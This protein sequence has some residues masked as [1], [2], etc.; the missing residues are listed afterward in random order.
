MPI[1]NL[2]TEPWIPV[3]D[4]GNLTM[5]SLEQALLEGHR[6]NRLEDPS[7]LVTT[8]LHR[9]MLAVLH[10]ALQGPVDSYQAEG[11]FKNGFDG[12]KIRAYLVKHHDRFDLFHPEKPFYQVPDFTLER[13]SRSWTVLAPELNS[14]NNKVLFDHTVTSRPRPIQ[15]AEAARL[16]VAN[17]TFAIS[18]GKSVLCHT[19]TAPVA[20][21]ALAL[22][23]GENLH[24]TLCLNLVGYSTSEH[25]RD[26]ATWERPPLRVSDMEN[27]E[28]ARATP[29]GIV[30]RYTWLSRSVRLEPEEEHG[31]AVVRW[32]AYASG[33]RYEE[34]AIR[35][36]PMVAFR[37]DPKDPS[38]RYPLGFRE[39]R[40]LWRDFASLLPKPGSMHSLGVVDQARNV[41][42]VLGERFRERGIPVMVAGQANDQAKVELWRGE[43]FRLPEAILSDKD[44]WRFVEENLERA[45]EM[46][47]ALNG[48]ARVLATQLLTLGD[49]RP[50]KDDVNKLVQSFPHQAAYWSA[51]EG[52]FT[53]WIQQL[54]LDFETKQERLKQ[55]WQAVLLREALRAWQLTKLAAGD[56][57]RALR[58]IY[59]SEGILLAHIHQQMSP[60]VLKWTETTARS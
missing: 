18:A 1:F 40:A 25:E 19:A 29:K 55:T 13:S 28:A 7:P 45:E 22:M 11:W 12:E 34:A 37:P 49:R 26:F 59:K 43:I 24:Q 23:L 17:Q 36:D 47:R 15:P 41:Y 50:H 8:A 48:A 2:I 9:L 14:D 31:Q 30:N 27:C 3:R 53:G 21:A 60:P 20:T 38:K 16:L 5:V 56:D 54:S 39:G 42:R 44:I 6:F 35:P 33:I 32:I 4:G 52:Q 57:A 46:G 58:A 10:R 51:L